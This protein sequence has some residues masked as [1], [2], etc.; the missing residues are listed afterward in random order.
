MYEKSGNACMSMMRMNP[1]GIIDND[2]MSDCSMVLRAN[3]KKISHC[4]IGKLSSYKIAWLP[5]ISSTIVT[6]FCMA[7]KNP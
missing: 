4:G 2:M 1:K 7:T 5:V 6:A 3:L